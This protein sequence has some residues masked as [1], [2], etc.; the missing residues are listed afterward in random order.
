M[1]QNYIHGGMF[2]WCLTMHLTRFSWHDAVFYF[3]YLPYS[4]S[5]SY[6]LFFFFFFSF[7]ASSPYSLVILFLKLS[8]Y[9]SFF[10]KRQLSVCYLMVNTL[11]G[12][13][14]ATIT[15]TITTITITTITTTIP[16]TTAL[17]FPYVL[18]FFVF[19]LLLLLLLF[20]RFHNSTDI[21]YLSL[22]LLHKFSSSACKYHVFW[23][24]YI[25]L[26]FLIFYV[27]IKVHDMAPI[28]H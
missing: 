5:S 27:Y 22:L 7:S 25:D 8:F 1:G 21:I 14:I 16:T 28:V 10:H 4:Y 6:Y 9:I 18:S 13:T 17:Y 26:H 3:S 11:C 19:L 2:S 15:K 12:I 24:F 20:S 23:T